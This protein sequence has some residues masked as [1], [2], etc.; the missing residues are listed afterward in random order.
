MRY[1]FRD[2]IYPFDSQ[3]TRINHKRTLPSASCPRYTEAEAEIQ[4]C[5]FGGVH[6]VKVVR[7]I[8][9][10]GV[11]VGCSKLV[12]WR[13]VGDC[14][15]GV[16]LAVIMAK[17]CTW[18]LKHFHLPHALLIAFW[19]CDLWNLPGTPVR[20]L[21]KGRQLLAGKESKRKEGSKGKHW[22]ST[23]EHSQKLNALLLV[24]SLRKWVELL[25]EYHWALRSVLNCQHVMCAKRV[26]ILQEGNC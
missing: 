26:L 24:S 9:S 23:V 6:Y 19:G 12:N 18:Y 7:A 15:G 11:G 25:A 17:L 2:W 3:I 4:T 1:L 16:W 14:G 10:N 21:G 22:N 5:R 8:M 20:Q 13:L